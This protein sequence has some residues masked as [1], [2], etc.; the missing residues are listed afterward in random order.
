MRKMSGAKPDEVSGKFAIL[1]NEELSDLYSSAGVVRAHDSSVNIVTYAV[2][3]TT[4]VRF[5]AGAGDIFS[6]LR[7]DWLW[8]PPSLPSGYPGITTGVK[9]PQRESKH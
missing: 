3:R 1:H 5:P 8:G 4:G 2:G 6:S 7:P 9:P